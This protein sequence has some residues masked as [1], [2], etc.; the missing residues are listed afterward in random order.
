VPSSLLAYMVGHGTQARRLQQ[1]K[2][3]SCESHQLPGTVNKDLG[4]SE[5]KV[6][7]PAIGS[8]V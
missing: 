1:P 6:E 7:M 4:L 8:N 3:H 2:G 5:K